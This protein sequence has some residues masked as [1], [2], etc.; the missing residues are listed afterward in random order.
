MVPT[1]GRRSRS[2][3]TADGDVPRVFVPL[4]D[5]R[6][7]RSLIS[8]AS[9][10]ARPHDGTVIAIHIVPLP[11]RASLAAGSD[12]LDELDAESSMLLER[13]ESDAETFGVDVQTRTIFSRRPFQEMFDAAR[14]LD[15]DVAVMGWNESHVARG[16]AESA[17][18]ELTNDLPC[19][20]LVLRDRGLDFSRLLV[21]TAGGPDSELGAEVAATLRDALCAEVTLLHVVD[22]EREREAGERFL[23]KWAVEHGLATADRHVDTADDVEKAIVEGADTETLVVAGATER[24]LLSRLVRGRPAYNI[25]EELSCS[26]LLAERPAERSLFERLF[27]RRDR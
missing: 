21:P 11:D 26:V 20:F 16:R 8:L 6:T 25:V 9:A 22:G 10:I 7:E 3:S 2:F 4:T 18:E 15:A 14:S 17:L 27:G 1:D 12:S 23:R 13:A 5:P 19:D 24:G